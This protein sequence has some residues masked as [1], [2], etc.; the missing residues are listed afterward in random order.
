MCV[1][2]LVLLR[3]VVTVNIAMMDT[4]HTHALSGGLRLKALLT[5]SK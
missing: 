2:I 4:Y 1:C 3:T 5:Y